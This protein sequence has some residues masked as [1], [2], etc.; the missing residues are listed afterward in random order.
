MIKKDLH[1]SLNSLV[2]NNFIEEGESEG[3]NADNSN[4]QI[5]HV[6]RDCLA[7]QDASNIEDVIVRQAKEHNLTTLPRNYSSINFNIEGIEA[8][9][10]E[11]VKSDQ[12]TNFRS[13]NHENSNQRQYFTHDMIL[14]ALSLNKKESK[15]DSGN[16][17]SK[18]QL[19]LGKGRTGK[20]QTLGVVLTTLV[21]ENRCTNKKNLVQLLQQMQHLM[22]VV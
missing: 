4:D 20:S 22:H 13:V 21:N 19:L 11:V 3:S 5:E 9:H 8:K 17:M 7:N 16:D 18:L 10:K 2:N 6:N 12:V 14:K 15:T 1:K